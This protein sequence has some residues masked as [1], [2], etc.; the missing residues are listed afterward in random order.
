MPQE[1]SL[2]API[3]EAS[4]QQQRPS[5][6]KTKRAEPRREEGKMVMGRAYGTAALRRSVLVLPDVWVPPEGD[7]EARIYRQA[8]Y[9]DHLNKHGTFLGHIHKHQ[10]E[11]FCFQGQE[12]QT[13]S[14]NGQRK[15]DFIG[16]YD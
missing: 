10:L 4:G 16:S 2:C 11:M 12:T 8:V 6:A 1:V 5:T 7:P 9:L 13:S 14:I 15:G 3:R